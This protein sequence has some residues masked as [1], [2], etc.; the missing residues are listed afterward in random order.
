MFFVCVFDI[1]KTFLDLLSSLTLV[2]TY[3]MDIYMKVL[4]S[5]LEGKNMFVFYECF[6]PSLVWIWSISWMLLLICIWMICLCCINLAN[7]LKK[8][9]ASAN[10]MFCRH[11]TL[12]VMCNNFPSSYFPCHVEEGKLRPDIYKMFYCR[13]VFRMV[14]KW[15]I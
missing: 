10:F 13:W 6:L 4:Q 11:Y 15:L 2:R 1:I 9:S 14:P 8:T 5:F 12:N 7:Y 3:K